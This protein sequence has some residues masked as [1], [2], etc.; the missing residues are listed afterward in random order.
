MMLQ[1]EGFAWNNS[2]WG[3][4]HEDFFAPVDIPVVPHKPWVLKN[5]P[6]PPSLYKEVCRII[7]SK[8]DAGV[9][10][11]SNSSY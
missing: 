6:I 4:F 1:S 5:I 11:Q 3:R 10:E 9:Y 8:L 7:K 2:E